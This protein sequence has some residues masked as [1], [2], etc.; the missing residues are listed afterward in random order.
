MSKIKL[1]KM[2]EQF[3]IKGNLDSSTLLTIRKYWDV[4]STIDR[5]ILDNLYQVQHVCRLGIRKH[6]N[7]PS[8]IRVPDSLYQVQHISSSGIRKYCDVPSILNKHSWQSLPIPTLHY[9]A[10]Q[11]RIN[12]SSPSIHILISILISVHFLKK[13]V[14]REFDKIS[15]HFTFRDHFV[16]SH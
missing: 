7:V 2:S 8:M 5:S 11:N 4:P 3:M 16:N 9:N 13:L 12:P 6:W 1:N 14:L 15:K 10:D